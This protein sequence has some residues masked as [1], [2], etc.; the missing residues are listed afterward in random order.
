MLTSQGNYLLNT[1][2]PSAFASPSPDITYFP[3]HTLPIVPAIRFADLFLTRTPWRPD[4][5]QPFLLGLYRE[6]DSKARD[7]LIAKFVRVVKD[8]D[9]TWWFPRRSS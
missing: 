5:M 8:K 3:A 6:G 9:G 7:K 1:P 4:D 2:P